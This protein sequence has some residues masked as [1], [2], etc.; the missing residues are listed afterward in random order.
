MILLLLQFQILYLLNHF[1]L[2]NS[3]SQMSEMSP[4]LSAENDKLVF[5]RRVE[6]KN[7]DPQEDFIIQIRLTVNGKKQLLFHT[8]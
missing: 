4:A 8:L 2:G 5:T 7:K 3:N 6:E 1:N